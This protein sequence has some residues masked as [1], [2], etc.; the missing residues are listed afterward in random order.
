MNL[1]CPYCDKPVD[2][3]SPTTLTRIVGWERRALGAHR[4]G[5]SACR[6][7]LFW[8]RVERGATDECWLWAGATTSYGYG[9]FYNFPDHP[10]RHAHRVSYELEVG[11][12]PEGLTIDHLCGV[13]KCVNPGHLEPVTQSENTRR[14]YRQMT[15][16]KHG[17]EFTP[18]NTLTYVDPR[19]GYR[20]RKCR[21]CHRASDRRQAEAKRAAA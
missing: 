3:T 14:F 7:C 6:R 21:A 13:K 5:G 17:H 16:C 1:V 18:E 9:I 2:P 20:R 11:E 8:S 12:I 19:D 10:P 15:H 4:R